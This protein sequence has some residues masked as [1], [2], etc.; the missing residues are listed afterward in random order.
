MANGLSVPLNGNVVGEDGQQ[1]VLGMR[2]EHLTLASHGQ[3]LPATVVVV[4]PTGADTQVFARVGETEVTAVFRERHDF[5][6][7]DSIRL[8]PD[9]GRSHLFD[10]VTGMSLMA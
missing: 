3:G 1:V 4:E 5:R 6:A 9:H 7:G 2:P 8:L 10:A